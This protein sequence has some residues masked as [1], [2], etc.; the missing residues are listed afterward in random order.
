MNRSQR[1]VAVLYCFLVAY[2]CAWIPWHV[3]FVVESQSSVGSETVNPYQGEKITRSRTV[4]SFIWNAPSDERN[5]RW[6]PTPAIDLILLRIVAVTAVCG[7]A[8]F[9]VGLW[10]QATLS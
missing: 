8:F 9:L 10:K 6:I 1:I 5:L 2:C 3:T 7:A 4:Y